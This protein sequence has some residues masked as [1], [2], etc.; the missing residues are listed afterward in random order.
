V[1]ITAIGLALLAAAFLSASCGKPA[2][3]KLIRDLLP[4]DGHPLVSF[5]ILV[6]IGSANDPSGQEGLARLTWSMLAQC[7][8][9]LMSFREIAEKF[10]PMAADLTVDVNKAI[11]KYLNFDNVCI[12]VVTQDAE[13]LKADLLANAPSPVKYANPNMPPEVLSEDTVIQEYPLAVREDKV[14][15]AP[16]ADFFRKSG[17]PGKQER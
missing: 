13:A 17:L 7:G 4:I 10:T 9:R 15:T 16:A 5:R 6:R 14:T 3:R 1:K 11:R 12:A 2:P 8:S